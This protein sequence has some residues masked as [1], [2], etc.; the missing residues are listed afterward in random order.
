MLVC[1]VPTLTSNVS[2]FDHSIREPIKYYTASDT[3]SILSENENAQ[4][5]YPEY[6]WMVVAK[7][8][9]REFTDIPICSIVNSS[10][11]STKFQIDLWVDNSYREAFPDTWKDRLRRRVLYANDI[12]RPQFD[13]ELSI[14]KIIEWNSSFDR[15]LENTLE[16]LYSST[17]SNPNALQI[18]ITFNKDL[19]RNWT[20]KND[21]GFAYLLSNDAVITAQPSFPSIGQDWNSIEEAITL[22]HEVGHM[23]GAIHVP[24]ENSIMYPSAGS[25]TFEFDSVNRKLIEAIKVNFLNQN[26]KERIITYSDELVKIKDFP[27]SNSNPILP[28]ITNVVEQIN[29]LSQIIN[30][31]SEKTFSNLYKLLPDSATTLA[32][33]GYLDFQ[34][35]EYERAHNTFMKVLEINPDFAEVQYYLS[36]ICRK[37]G[38][39]KQADFY[40]NLAKP[41]SKLW[42]IEK[43]GL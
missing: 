24:D 42:I 28:A 14:S 23:L 30:K 25:L 36:L 5:L 9:S 12:L 3:T 8:L 10:P 18:G 31:S 21:L 13:I 4:L 6:P 39:S 19:K 34:D 37:N 27:S 41:Y 38:D 26:Q 1:T 43:R 35:N 40:K 20:S 11:P 16:K 15:N 7:Q 33:M 2:F 32:V 22:V 17:A 29:Q